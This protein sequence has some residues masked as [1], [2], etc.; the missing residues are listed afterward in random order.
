MHD[1]L[2]RMVP[3]GLCFAL[4]LLAPTACA[5]AVPSAA[6]PVVTRVV[7]S[8][9]SLLGGTELRISADGLGQPQASARAYCQFNWS[10]A[11][12]AFNATTAPFAPAFAPSKV[13]GHHWRCQSLG[14][15]LSVTWNQCVSIRVTRSVGVPRPS[16]TPTA[17]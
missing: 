14:S 13:I 11:G 16:C 15:A 4:L 7:P 12:W 3:F 10:W 1:E 2:A 17:L 5:A 6:V 8:E 9:G